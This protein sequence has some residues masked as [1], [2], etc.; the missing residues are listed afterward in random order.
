LRRYAGLPRS[1]DFCLVA[2][3]G[4]VAALPLLL[5]T[6]PKRKYGD[7]VKWLWKLVNLRGDRADSPRP[8]P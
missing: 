4:L 7:A 8:W 2:D 6:E 3:T 5:S 1:Q